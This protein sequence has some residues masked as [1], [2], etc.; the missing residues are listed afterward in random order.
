PPQYPFLTQLVGCGP[1]IL[2]YADPNN[3]TAHVVKFNEFFINAPVIGSVI[4]E[5]W[6]P[7]PPHIQPYTFEVLVQNMA[8]KA[9]D[10]NG[11][12]TNATFYAKIYFD[13]QLIAI[14]DPILLGPFSSLQFGPYLVEP[15]AGCHTIKVEVYDAETGTLW[16]TY[17]HRFVVVVREDVTTYSGDLVDCFVDVM[18]IL[19]AAR[20]YGSYPGSPRWNPACDIDDNWFVDIMDLLCIVG[21]Y[22]WRP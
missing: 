8:A 9:N 2:H 5:W 21:K 12:L 13:S 15:T 11:E 7:P 17:I 22:G 16:H 20:A 6:Y 18:D 1:Y 4:G 14:T 19:T 3:L 10:E